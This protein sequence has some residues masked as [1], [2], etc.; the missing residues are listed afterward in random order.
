M[1]A[2]LWDGALPPEPQV[3]IISY[4]P[5]KPWPPYHMG[6][7]TEENV[8]LLKPGDLLDGTESL[9]RSMWLSYLE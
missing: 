4:I 6:E 7:F 5:I 2:E 1:H 3:G 8:I 9:I